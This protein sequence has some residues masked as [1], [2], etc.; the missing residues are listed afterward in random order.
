M[1]LKP[2]KKF[3][4]LNGKMFLD[5]T[6]CYPGMRNLTLRLSLALN[7]KMIMTMDNVNENLLIEQAIGE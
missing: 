1:I 3:N 7:A 6:C 4:I 5:H 2:S